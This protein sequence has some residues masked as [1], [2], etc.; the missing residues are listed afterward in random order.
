MRAIFKSVIGFLSLWFGFNASAAIGNADK[1]S[2]Y[3]YLSKS[4][5]PIDLDDSS[6]ID[7]VSKPRDY[8]TAILLTAVESRYGCQLCRDLQP[9]WDLLAKSWNKASRDLSTRLLFGTLDFDQ[10]KAVF[11]KLMLQT[12]PVLLLFPP[13]LGPEAKPDGSPLRYD[14]SGPMSADQLYTWISRYL[15]EGP[16]LQ[17]IRP[18]NYA[19]S[20]G[21]ATLVLSCSS[22]LTVLS[23]YIFPILQSQNVWAAL[24]LIAVLLFTSGHMFN[25]IRKVPYVTGDGKGGI[26]Y[27]AGGFSN[28][29]GLES[30]I[31]AAVCKFD[32]WWT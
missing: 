24:S 15:P 22:I 19:K 25:H 28:Q 23:P 12:A 3:Q 10:G 16:K 7:I 8:H 32:P 5:L 31:I 29:F 14:F 27:F 20:V 2:Q 26:T 30:Q 13:T 1:F 4:Y 21:V 18:I 9:E 17:I 11:Q 6:Y